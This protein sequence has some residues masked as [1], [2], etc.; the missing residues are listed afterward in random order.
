MLDYDSARSSYHKVCHLYA[1]GKNPDD[2]FAI[3]NCLPW[4]EIGLIYL[5]TVI[6]T[7]LQEV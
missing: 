6:Y 1:L 5:H 3:V 2:F 4:Q 7:S